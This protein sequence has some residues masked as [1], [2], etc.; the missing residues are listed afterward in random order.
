MGDQ[1]YRPYDNTDPPQET[2][3]QWVS[4]D[5]SAQSQDQYD[6]QAAMPRALPNPQPFSGGH[7]YPSQYFPT[8]GAYQSTNP[9]VAGNVNPGYM[10]PLP[11]ANMMYPPSALPQYQQSNFPNS[12]PL[13]S[14]D[15]YLTAY[16]PHLVPQF[17]E[18]TR[19]AFTRI[20]DGKE[21]Y[22]PSMSRQRGSTIAD[23]ASIE[24]GGR[25]WQ[26]YREGRYFLPNDAIEQDR[27]DFNHVPLTMLLND[28]LHLAPVRNPRRVL[29]IGTGTGIWAIHFAERNP[30]SKVIGTDL[31]MI[32]PA[33]HLKLPNIEFHRDDCEGDWIFDEAFDFI[34]QRLMFTGINDPQALAK[35]MY[36]NLEPGGWAEYQDT[37]IHVESDDRSHIG[38]AVHQWGHLAMAAAAAKGRDMDVSR[39]YKDYLTN[40]GFVDVTEKKLKLW[41]NHWPSDPVAKKIGKYTCMS[42]VEAVQAM[43]VKLLQDGLEWPVKDVEG[44]VR[45]AQEDMK[46]P[47]I[48]WYLP[49]YVVYGRKPLPNEI[50][51]QRE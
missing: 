10:Q 48:R 28:A 11:A 37:T 29:D 5:Q 4:Q 1:R 41:G 8:Q 47:N 38:T 9:L 45:R 23:P 30:Y 13:Q 22:E 42:C 6:P 46:N 40:A 34:H 32:Q 44:L 14:Q 36:D 33:V 31:S 17:G 21:V 50:A 26:N 16:E 20:K 2:N 7:V 49:F 43:S 12:A 18:V 25:T 51:T 19:R 39:K 24:E 15:Q 35:K 3:Y 27:L